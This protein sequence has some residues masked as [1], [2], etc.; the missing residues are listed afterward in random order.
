M[1]RLEDKVHE[2]LKLGC[3]SGGVALYFRHSGH[4]DTLFVRYLGNG[5]RPRVPSGS[6]SDAR[7]VYYSVLSPSDV[8]QVSHMCCAAADAS[9]TSAK[10]GFSSPH[11]CYCPRFSIRP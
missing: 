5:G 11:M 6:F 9:Q 10:D 4:S 7:F 2:Q 8:E 1:C 3:T